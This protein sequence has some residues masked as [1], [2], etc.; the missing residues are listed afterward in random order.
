MK[1][2]YPGFPLAQRSRSLPAASRMCGH[3][4]GLKDFFGLLDQCFFL[5]TAMCVSGWRFP[6]QGCAFFKTAGLVGV[7]AGVV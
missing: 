1:T 7:G 6:E 5:F 3:H 2:I 4:V